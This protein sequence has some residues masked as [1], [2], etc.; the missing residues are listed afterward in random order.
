MSLEP[1][2]R[3]ASLLQK[4]K[5]IT[6]RCVWQTPKQKTLSKRRRE[7]KL[8]GDQRGLLAV[9]NGKFFGRL[10][11]TLRVQVRKEGSEDAFFA[12]GGVKKQE[13]IKSKEGGIRQ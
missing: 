8:I 7:V 11:M 9:A 3:N 5:E 2:V 4:T 1:A 10:A 13:R 12:G 6:R